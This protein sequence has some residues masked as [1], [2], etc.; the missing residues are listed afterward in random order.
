MEQ[1]F[2][3]WQSGTSEFEDDRLYMLVS[4]QHTRALTLTTCLPAQTGKLPG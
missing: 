4:G 3:P 1:E 2:A